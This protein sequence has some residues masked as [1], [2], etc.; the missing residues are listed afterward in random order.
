MIRIILPIA[1]ALISACSEPPPV[2]P[3]KDVKK[4]LKK[5]AKKPPRTQVKA[6]PLGGDARVHRARAALAKVKVPLR[7]ALTK[8]LAGG[9]KVAALNA[10]ATIAP[11]I[12]SAPIDGVRVGRTSEKL[13]SQKNAGPAWTTSILK[14]LR[15]SKPASV[16][17]KTVEIGDGKLGYAEPIYVGQ[18]C[19][20]CHGDV[21]GSLAKAISTQYPSDS[22]TGYT[23][24][25]FRGIFWA[26]V[27]KS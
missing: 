20:T 10:C 5:I 7:Q 6:E 13:R 9:D 4:V 21:D 12:T 22:A 17:F 1:F 2:A 26:E 19:L 18:M 8:S 25:E 15:D 3:K 14:E 11:G 24:G 16:G 23:L 27:P